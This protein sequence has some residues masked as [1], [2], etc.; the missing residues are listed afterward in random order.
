MKAVEI[1]VEVE[2]EVGAYGADGADGAAGA[3][4]V[5][6]VDGILSKANLF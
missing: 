1:E 3:D 2:V 5:T 6:Y 4:R